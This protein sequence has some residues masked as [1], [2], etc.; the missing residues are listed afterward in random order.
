VKGLPVPDESCLGVYASHVL[1]HLSLDDFHT[2]LENTFRMLR[3]GG[4]FRLVVPD[5]EWA[6]RA[7]VSRLDYGEDTANEFFMRAT[8]LGCERIERGPVAFARRFRSTA[9]HLWMWD[10][11]SMTRALASHGFQHI[12][13][14]QLGDCEDL[15]F[16]FVE[17]PGRFENALALESRR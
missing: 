2:A 15:M 1:E 5:L 10:A 8:S 14:C 11:A 6:A 9:G 7:Y 4:I 13:R 17:D 12:R 3:P 16:S